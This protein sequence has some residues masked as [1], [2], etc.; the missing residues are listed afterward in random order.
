[1]ISSATSK[2]T[3][4]IDVFGVPFHADISELTAGESD[5]NASYYSLICSVFSDGQLYINLYKMR[6]LA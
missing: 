2:N 1:M 6:T 5:M 4:G 3:S